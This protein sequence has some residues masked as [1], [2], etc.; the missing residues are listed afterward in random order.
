M[1]LTK[2]PGY[3]SWIAMKQRCCNP[4]DTNYPL[5]GGRGI[6][7]CD[8]WLNSSANFLADMGP[9][10]EGMTLE[11]INT[12]GNY[13]P[14]NCVWANSSQQ[15]SSRRFFVFPTTNPTPNIY[16]IRSKYALKVMI[17]KNNRHCAT[18]PTLEEAE[19]A[20]AICYFERDFLA[21]HNLSY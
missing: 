10:P 16:P 21:Y 1:L 20:R 14:S 7:V 12:N 4:N 11:R 8:R 6:T 17:T 9:R 15:A 18:Y 2:T 19:Q 5:Y 3:T 13:E